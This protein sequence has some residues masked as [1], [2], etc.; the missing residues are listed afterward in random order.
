MAKRRFTDQQ[1]TEIRRRVFKLNED[2][3]KVMQ[4]LSISPTMMYRI[5]G[6]PIK[7]RNWGIENIYR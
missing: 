4:E 5:L 7:H 1:E 2:A 6:G 3:T